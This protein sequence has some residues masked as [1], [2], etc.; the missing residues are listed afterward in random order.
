MKN[1]T[2]TLIIGA[3]GSLASMVIAEWFEKKNSDKEVIDVPCEEISTE[4][5]EVTEEVK[6]D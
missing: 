5:V 3:I 1:K 4:E 2:K 6:E